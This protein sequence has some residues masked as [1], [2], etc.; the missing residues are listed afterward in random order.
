MRRVGRELG[1]MSALWRTRQQ[2]SE[3][4]VTEATCV[5]LLSLDLSAVLLMQQPGLSGAIA[6]RGRVCV[7]AEVKAVKWKAM[8][9]LYSQH[10]AYRGHQ[11]GPREQF[12]VRC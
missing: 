6:T 5:Q 12:R 4:P 11:S 1:G 3:K 2:A 10:E 7:Q 9:S 8:V